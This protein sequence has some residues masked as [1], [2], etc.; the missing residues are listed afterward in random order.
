MANGINYVPLFKHIVP[1]SI[2]TTYNKTYLAYQYIY[3]NISDKYDWY[4]KG[5]ADSY[6]FVENLRYF[7]SQFDP[8]KPYYLGIRVRHV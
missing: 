3:R 7:L 8:N 2:H 1:E 6:I 4:M 5:E